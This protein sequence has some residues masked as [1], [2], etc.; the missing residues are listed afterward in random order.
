MVVG[1]F[2]GEHR[3]FYTNPSQKHDCVCGLM[4]STFARAKR[5]LNTNQG[6]RFRQNFIKIGKANLVAQICPLLAVPIITRL[7]TPSDFGVAALFTSVLEICLAAVSMKVDWSV[8]NATSRTQAVGLIVFGF[9]ISFLI[10][11]GIYILFWKCRGIFG[12]WKGFEN[13]GPLLFL[14]PVALTGSVLQQLIQ[15]WHIR[16]RE[17]SS[18]G[19]A[20]IAQSIVA[21]STKLGFGLT[22]MGAKGLILS[23]VVSAW[24]GI[25]MMFRN[26]RGF[27]TAIKRLKV[28]RLFNTIKRFWRE[29]VISTMIALV[30]VT[31][32]SILPLLFSQFYSTAE[33]GH[34]VFMHKLVSTPIGIVTTALGQS[35][36]AEAAHLIRKDRRQL[37]YLYFRST[38]K[39]LWV[40]APVALICLCG[41]FYI[42]P[43]F[44]REQWASAGLILAVL[45]PFLVGQIVVAPLSHLIIHRKQHWQFLWDLFRLVGLVMLVVGFCSFGFSIVTVVLVT[46]IFHFMTY[47]SLFFLNKWAYGND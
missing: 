24:I 39:L 1:Y 19:N 44:G 29:S 15:S 27:V 32:L 25:L 43:I 17:L 28:V 26:A 38:N 34:Y 36:W 4:G 46:S 33:V 30:N 11:I 40:A 35:F 45:T 2:T 21:T 10:N 7:Y 18:V 47:A 20:K 37:K 3:N 8:P 23:V 6:S 13:L 12:F 5:F 42:G 22:S 31:S 14:I 16:E 41:P 9:L